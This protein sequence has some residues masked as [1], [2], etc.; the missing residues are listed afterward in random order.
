MITHIFGKPGSGKTSYGVHVALETVRAISNGTAPYRFV[1]SNI[2]INHPLVCHIPFEF[3]GKYNLEDALIIID[4]ATM[5]ADSRDYKG[6]APHVR[7]FMLEHRH[8]VS[9]PQ[10]YRCDII[11]ISQG[12]NRI[13]KTIRDL[14]EK[15]LYIKKSFLPH[16]SKI[17]PLNYGYNIPIGAPSAEDGES[18]TISEGYFIP[19]KLSVLFAKRFNRKPT[20]SYYNSWSHATLPDIPRGYLYSDR[21]TWGL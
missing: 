19:S 18:S 14:T 7:N 16:Q 6:F 5:F 3:L 15:V 13:D 21:A 4:E 10:K 8:H 1:F 9:D 20:Y 12:Y 2:D 17:I 11:F